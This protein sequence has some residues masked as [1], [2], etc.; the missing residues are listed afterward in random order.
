MI[1]GNNREYCLIFDNGGIFYSILPLRSRKPNVIKFRK[2]NS[3]EYATPPGSNI[4]KAIFYYKN[5][6]LSES[7]IP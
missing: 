2:T 7:G 1:R 6:I 4:I 5:V 3:I